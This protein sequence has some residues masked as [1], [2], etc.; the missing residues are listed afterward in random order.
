MSGEK[1]EATNYEVFAWGHGFVG[2]RPT[3]AAA[4]RLAAEYEGARIIIYEAGAF[5]V[6]AALGLYAPD[7][8]DQRS[9]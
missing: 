7:R 6:V 9:A 5:R 1:V 4:R 2:S 3:L 8:A